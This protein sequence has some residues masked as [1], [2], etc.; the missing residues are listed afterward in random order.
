MGLAPGAVVGAHFSSKNTKT[1]EKGTPNASKTD[2]MG[3]GWIH[4]RSVLSPL[5]CQ[6][7]LCLP[8]TTKIQHLAPKN[9]KNQPIVKPKTNIFN[10]QNQNFYCEFLGQR[11][12]NTT[13]KNDK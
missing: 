9:S 6:S 2:K 10:K 1:N 11:L 4:R 12:F 5:G 13:S 8:K 7:C 3:G